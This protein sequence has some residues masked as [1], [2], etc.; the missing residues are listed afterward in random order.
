MHIIWTERLYETERLGFYGYE[1]LATNRGLIWSQ[2]LPLLKK[3]LFLGAGAN[4]FV[5]LYPQNNYKDIYYYYGTMQVMTKPHNMY[6]QIAAET[7]VILL[8]ALLIFWGYYLVHSAKLY[9]NCS[10]DCLSKRLGFG[11][12][13][14]V[15][16]YLGCGLANDSMISVAPIFWC[17]QGVGLAANLM[18]QRN[19]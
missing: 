2:T 10:F 16:V 13:L 12:A 5:H 4:N 8:L 3:T 6:L 1:T 7:G 14:A 17:V 15:L 9:W 11:C 19:W 18:N